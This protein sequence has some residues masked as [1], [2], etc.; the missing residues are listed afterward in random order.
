VI[1]RQQFQRIATLFS[2]GLA[3][4]LAASVHAH[5]ELERRIA[6]LTALVEREPD[7][8]RHWLQ[9]GELHREHGD[10]ARA[11]AD[12][13][14]AAK[15]DPQLDAVE[16]ARARVCLDAGRLAEVIA[17]TSQFL[18][19]Q[20][21][22]P[23]ALV[24]RAQAAERLGQHQAS[25]ADYLAAVSVLPKPSP[26]LV[27]QTARA[28]AADQR[29]AEAVEVL[30]AGIAKLGSVP[31]LQQ[32]AIDYERQLKRHEA[33]LKRIAGVIARYPRAEPWLALQ[34][35]VL[36]EAGRR[37]EAREVAQRALTALATQPEHR[38][39]LPMQLELETR[40]RTL[41]A[42]LNLSAAVKGAVAQP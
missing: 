24:V 12:F 9:R 22:H 7:N 23:D 19:R 1:A 39:Q 25:A 35:E 36:E 38:R 42:R 37:A 33:A 31:A 28:L 27:L 16:L 20:P 13:E 2:A 30:D 6:A 3:L 29:L 41:L 5:P 10:F 17:I 26:D 8:A 40:L 4:C 15:R 18:G 14:A 21:R 34:A 32:T 11:L